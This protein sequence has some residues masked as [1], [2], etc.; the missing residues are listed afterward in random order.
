MYVMDNHVGV[1]D[2]L[3]ICVQVQHNCRYVASLMCCSQ[4]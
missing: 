3:I 4:L 2:M 1:A